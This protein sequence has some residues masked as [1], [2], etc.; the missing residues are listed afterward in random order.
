VKRSGAVV[1]MEIKAN[2]FLHHMVRN[3]MGVLIKVGYGEKPVTWVKEVLDARLRTAAGITAPPH[4]LYL[5]KVDYPEVFAL[6][7]S[8][9]GHLEERGS[10]EDVLANNMLK[11]DFC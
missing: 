1:V 3:I 4:G 8:N 10:F 2:A 9:I 5:L 7:Q 6:P 11:G